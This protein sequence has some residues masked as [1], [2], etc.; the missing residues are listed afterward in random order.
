MKRKE[1]E[2]PQTLSMEIELESCF[3]ASIGERPEDTEGGITIQHQDPGK[4]IGGSGSG[5]SDG[6]DFV[7]GDGKYDWDI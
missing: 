6:S 3:C 5:W 4:A 7:N 2:S 1:Y